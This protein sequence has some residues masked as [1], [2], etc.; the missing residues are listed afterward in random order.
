MEVRKIKDILNRKKFIDLLLIG[1]EDRTMLEK[2]MGL[3][4]MYVLYRQD[5]VI[6]CILTLEKNART[7]EIKNISIYPEYRQMG[8]GRYLVEYVVKKYRRKYR[9]LIVG[10]GDSPLTLP[11]YQ[12]LDFKKYY[13]VRDFFTKNYEEEIIEAGVKL[14]DMVYLERHL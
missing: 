10:T 1:D 14:R 3:G 8:Y 4:N 2:Y 13:V 12:A 7:L 6:G 9:K 11:F 5:Q